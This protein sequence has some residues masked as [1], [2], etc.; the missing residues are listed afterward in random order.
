M[1]DNVSQGLMH[2]KTLISIGISIL[3][4]LFSIKNPKCL[5]FDCLFCTKTTPAEKMKRHSNLLIFW[6]IMSKFY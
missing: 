6:T 3:D 5:H 2:L 4:N 1:T